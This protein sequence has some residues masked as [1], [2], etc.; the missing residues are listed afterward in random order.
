M[1][2]TKLMEKYSDFDFGKFT[3]TEVGM[4]FVGS[5]F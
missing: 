5:C 2:V 1:D 3:V 4:V